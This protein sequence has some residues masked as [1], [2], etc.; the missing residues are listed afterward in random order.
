VAIQAFNQHHLNAV[1][2]QAFNQPH[3]NAVAI[4]AFNQTQDTRGY[5][6]L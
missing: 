3:L 2:I 6:S 4:Q 1:A 5:S